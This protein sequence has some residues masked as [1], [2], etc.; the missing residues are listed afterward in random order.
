MLMA[1]L[2]SYFSLPNNSNNGLYMN[3][4]YH[5]MSIKNHDKIIKK[6][7]FTYWYIITKNVFVFVF[8]KAKK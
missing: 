7:S 8:L 4:K 2:T 5:S 3:M 1:H 6:K